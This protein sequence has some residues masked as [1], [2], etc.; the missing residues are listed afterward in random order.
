MTATNAPARA[1]SRPMT[2]ADARAWMERDRMERERPPADETK[3]AVRTTEFYVYLAS[4]AAVLLASLLVG[5][6]NGDRDWFRSDRAWWYVS[7]LTI[8]YLISRGLAKAGSG[9]RKSEIR[10]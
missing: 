4:V 3:P 1:Q 2:E 9:W 6:G 10:Q 5:E 8:G 7:L